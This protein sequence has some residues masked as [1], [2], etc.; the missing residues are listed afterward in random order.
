MKFICILDR[1]LFLSYTKDV[2]FM[3]VSSRPGPDVKTHSLAVWFR[4]FRL[5]V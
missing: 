5:A 2:T 3:E 1:F 4:T